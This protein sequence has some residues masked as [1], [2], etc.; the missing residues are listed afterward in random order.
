MNRAQV[1]GACV[2]LAVGIAAPVAAASAASPVVHEDTS[3]FSFESFDAQYYL[4]LDAAGH[5]TTRVVETL[6]ADFP[7]FDQNRGIIRAIPLDDQGYS[8]D[9]AMNSVTD[10]NGDPVYY[11][12][13]D[14]DGF[15]EFALGTD[16]FVHGPTTYV[17]DYT[18]SNTIRHFADSGVDEFYWDI[19]GTGWAQRF[20]T[21]SAH[22]HVSDRL[23]ASLTGAASCYVGAY[24]VTTPCDITNDGGVFA[25]SAGPVS[26]YETLT[27]A[28]GFVGGTVVQPTLP[29]DSWIV[30][31][32]PKVLLGIEGLLVAIGILIRTVIWRDAR[33]RGTIIAQFVPPKGSHLLL[34]ANIVKRP[35]SGLQ[36]QLVDF[37]VRGLIN[38]IDNHPGAPVG[39]D[40]TRFSIELKTADGADPHELRVLVMLF[41]MSLQPGKRVNPGQFSAAVGASLYGLPA[42][43]ASFAIEEGY[44][45]VVKG[46]APM[47]M[48]RLAFWTIVAFVPIW[49]WATIFDVL[50]GT[51]IWLSFGTI[52][53]GIALAIIL[54]RPK[55]LTDKGAEARDYLLGLREYLTIAEEDRMRVLQSPSGAQR[56]DVTDR[57]AVVK[58]NERLLGYAVLWGVEDQW[59]DKLRSEYVGGTPS[60]IEGGSF[61]AGV[62]RGFTASSVAS[63]RPIVTSSSGGG[64][65]WSSS[66]GSSFSSGSSGG[67]FSG[68]GG[69]GGGG[70]GR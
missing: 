21:V 15:A 14:Y 53:L 37:A 63:V 18:M 31:L 26:G 17:L 45:A 40:S 52:A 25:A 50:D 49:I 20:G 9:I 61:D 41:G 56:I 44:R 43:T 16:E 54:S 29:R 35:G 33:G 5:A 60:W 34:D 39:T 67:G 28:I 1:L 51:I 3:A 58:L 36:A 46:T 32:A 70:G 64:G 65:S 69:G 48:G 62:L 30:Q 57:D 10:E 11:E 7:Q 66:G 68:G 22:V 12:R 55:V 4:D 42:A 23:A 38:I 13:N 8:L 19:N 6:V 27:V 47:V 59:A 2:A 24:G